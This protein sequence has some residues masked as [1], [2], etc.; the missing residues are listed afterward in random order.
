MSSGEVITCPVSGESEQEMAQGWLSALYPLQGAGRQ[1]HLH[2]ADQEGR[3][4]GEVPSQGPGEKRGQPCP[5]SA[6]PRVL[7]LLCYGQKR[8]PPSH[9][10]R[11]RVRQSPGGRLSEEN[12][13][14]IPGGGLCPSQ[15]LWCGRPPRHPSQDSS[16]RTG[17]PISVSVCLPS[18]HPAPTS[19]AG[20][21]STDGPSPALL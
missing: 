16:L 12:A 8:V 21:G 20:R 9:D 18:P 2:C 15:S 19:L 4:E 7:P 5:P 11:H 1:G 17:L 14:Y 10:P 13:A 3:P 6:H